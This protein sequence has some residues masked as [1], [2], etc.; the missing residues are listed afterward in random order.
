MITPA[1]RTNPRYTFQRNSL[2]YFRY[3]LPPDISKVVGKQGL[4]YS[5]KTGY[6]KQAERKA[7]R[8][9]GTVEELALNDYEGINSHVDGLLKELK[10]KPDKKSNNYKNLCREL[11]KVNIR[12][13][14]ITEKRTVGDYSDQFST[15]TFSNSSK[16]EQKDQPKLSKAIP[17][18][19]SEFMKADR[20][21]EKTKSENGGVMKSI[22]N[23]LMV[24]LAFTALQVSTVGAQVD[25][26]ATGAPMVPALDADEN[27]ITMPAVASPSIVERVKSYI[28]IWNDHGSRE[29][30]K[31][32]FGGGIGERVKSF[33]GMGKVVAPEL[34][35]GTPPVGQ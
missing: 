10:V 4:G 8:L 1:S 16:A 11:L 33:F 2:Y 30:L 24:G 27:P 3:T 20:W 21:T 31:R 18:F 26:G 22:F 34:T 25:T 17:K 19:V 15:S 13:L 35:D 32:F 9:A 7:R 6:I 23:F 29:V 14:D 12:I 28:G 5:L